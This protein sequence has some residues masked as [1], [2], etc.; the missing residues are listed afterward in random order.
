[1]DRQNLKK[2]LKKII[3]KYN[4]DAVLSESNYDIT[5]IVDEIRKESNIKL[6]NIFVL[7]FSP[8][9]EALYNKSALLPIRAIKTNK[10]LKKIKPLIILLLQ[11]YFAHKGIKY[12][13]KGYN[14][15]YQTADKVVVLS[16]SH[17]E[18][19]CKFAKLVNSKKFYII[20]NALSLPYFL[21]VSDYDKVKKKDV[22]IVSRLDEVVKRVS[23][24]LKIWNKICHEYWAKDWSLKIA[25]EGP[26]EEDYKK[27]VYKHHLHNVDFLGRV[28]PDDYY[29]EA[30]I[31]MMTSRTEGFG[32]SLTESLQNGV[33]P[34]AFD[35]FS[36]VHDIISDGENGF[37]I[38]EG[39]IDQYCEKLK[40]LMTNNNI[41]KS[42][43]INSITS[44]KRFLPEKIGKMWW[45]LLNN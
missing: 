10:G 1:M 21:D 39:H 12:L 16:K 9:G 45:H 42:M 3:I 43:A 11:P 30:S 2:D 18:Q 41:R 22:L 27:Y 44:S 31:Y 6:Q 38:T 26:F 20:P 32:L 14:A 40:L 7:H 35:S 17:P 5:P 34:I 33:V 36:A 4:I 37:I 19:Y 8:G 28:K 15:A 24:A 23:L 25:G 29:K 13:S